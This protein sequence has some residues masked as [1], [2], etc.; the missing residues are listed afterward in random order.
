[1]II[2]TFWASL[3]VQTVKNLPAMEKK[4]VQ[5]LGRE[6]LVEKG[7]AIHPVFLP[8]DPHGQRSLAG[9]SPWGCKRVGCN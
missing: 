5:S 9:N 7:M 4:C 8:V 1:M 6:D 2:L 3:M